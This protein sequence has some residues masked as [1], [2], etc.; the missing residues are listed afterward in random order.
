MKGDAIGQL[1]F[2]RGWLERRRD[3]GVRKEMN[4]EMECTRREAGNEAHRWRE[5][6]K[7]PPPGSTQKT[8]PAL[9]V[10]EIVDR[11]KEFLCEACRCSEERRAAHEIYIE[12]AARAHGP[13]DVGFRNTDGIL[14]LTAGNYSVHGLAPRPLSLDPATGLRSGLVARPTVWL[15]QGEKPFPLSRLAQFQQAIAKRRPG[16][17]H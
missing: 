6:L 4:C 17:K 2:S 5:E 8:Q 3:E 10:A 11:I 9:A 14:I 7:G 13:A 15:R 1:G 12:R 16:R